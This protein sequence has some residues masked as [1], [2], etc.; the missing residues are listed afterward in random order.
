MQLGKFLAITKPVPFGHFQRIPSWTTIWD[1]NFVPWNKKTQSGNLESESIWCQ[2]SMWNS[3]AHNPKFPNCYNI[4]MVLNSKTVGPSTIPETHFLNSNW[5][6]WGRLEIPCIGSIDV[7][8]TKET[9]RTETT[10]NQQ[11]TSNNKQ[12]QPQPQP[13]PQQQQQQQQQPRRRRRQQQQQQEQQQQ[14]QPQQQQQQQ[15][16]THCLNGVRGALIL[17]RLDLSLSIVL[18]HHLSDE[19]L[20]KSCGVLFVPLATRRW[21][22]SPARRSNWWLN[23]PNTLDH[24]PR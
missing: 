4:N 20:S 18:Q 21:C 1:D 7:E 16:Q 17:T 14:Q 19:R 9:L 6:I 12:P 3:T 23:H 10:N 15:Q 22:P 13:Q 2:N 24:L 5:M 11:P 8:G